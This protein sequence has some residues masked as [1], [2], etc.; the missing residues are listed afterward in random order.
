MSYL[1]KSTNEFSSKRRRIKISLLSSNIY[2]ENFDQNDDTF[3]RNRKREAFKT[4]NKIEEENQPQQNIPFNT[5]QSKKSTTHQ[6]IQLKLPICG[7]EL[8]RKQNFGFANPTNHPHT[9]GSVNSQNLKNSFIS[10]EK[11]IVLSSIEVDLHF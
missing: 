1:P 2:E 3:R 11:F 7:L 4:I 6:N 9:K 10:Q 8:F 5:L